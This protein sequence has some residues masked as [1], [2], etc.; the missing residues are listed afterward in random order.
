MYYVK[1]SEC[2]QKTSF[3]GT[4]RDS[5]NGYSICLKCSSVVNIVNG[6]KINEEEWDNLLPE[7]KAALDNFKSFFSEQS[8]KKRTEELSHLVMKHH[9][10]FNDNFEA[11]PIKSIIENMVVFYLMMEHLMMEPEKNTF[12]KVIAGLEVLQTI[13]ESIGQTKN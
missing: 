7:Q 3:R 5:I 10:M 6:K 13:Q 9:Q 8:L 4:E 11:A 1:C 2:N 12:I